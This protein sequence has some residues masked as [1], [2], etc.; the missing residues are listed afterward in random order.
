MRDRDR[1]YYPDNQ[2]SSGRSSANK[3]D[4]R[5]ETSKPPSPDIKQRRSVEKPV[6]NEIVK[7]KTPTLEDL[8]N[9]TPSV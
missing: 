8:L 4:N 1:K 6:A 5:V 3:S 2:E 7:K 9:E